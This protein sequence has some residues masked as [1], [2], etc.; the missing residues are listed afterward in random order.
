MK[1]CREDKEDRKLDT[2]GVF[3]DLKKKKKSST[4]LKLL[5]RYQC[6]MK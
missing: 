3:S 2:R 6:D 5:K 4:G 1:Q